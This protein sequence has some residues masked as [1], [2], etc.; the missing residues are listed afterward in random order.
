[1]YNKNSR[2]KFGKLLRNKKS[3]LMSKTISNL[4]WV[5]TNQIYY[6]YE[7]KKINHSLVRKQNY[8]HNSYGRIFFLML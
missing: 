5:F 2:K 1:M 6:L 4:I 7:Q 3:I 8:S